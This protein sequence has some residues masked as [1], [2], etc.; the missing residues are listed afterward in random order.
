MMARRRDEGQGVVE[1]ALIL[2]LFV[3]LVVGLLDVAR[4]VW[5]ENTLAFAAREGTRYAIVH[6]TLSSSPTGPGAPTFTAP[7]QDSA[8]TAAVLRYTSG[9]S[10]VTVKS[11]WPDSNAN[12]DSRVTVV[13]SAPFVP[14]ASQYF[15]SGALRVTLTGGSTMAV[16]R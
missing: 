9:L 7:D 2:P 3:V 16:Q 6:G 4:A 8:V 15:L 12:R 10:N 14:F 5:Q 13:A 11:V 1:F